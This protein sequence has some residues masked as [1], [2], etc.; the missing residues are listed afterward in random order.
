MENKSNE[1]EG[2]ER[3]S[4]QSRNKLTEF[5]LGILKRF[6]KWAGDISDEPRSESGWYLRTGEGKA[7]AAG[8]E[9]RGGKEDDIANMLDGRKSHLAMLA[10]AQA[11]LEEGAGYKDYL[12][13]V[14]TKYEQLLETEKRDAG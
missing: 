13:A 1:E 8:A 14:A 4:D 10:V 3:V 5:V 2:G 11:D 9:G 6:D 7:L 12:K